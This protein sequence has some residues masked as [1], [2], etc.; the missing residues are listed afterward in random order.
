MRLTFTTTNCNGLYTVCVQDPVLPMAEL[1]QRLSQD[2]GWDRQPP[3]SA[4]TARWAVSSLYDWQTTDTDLQQFCRSF[5][6]PDIKRQLL[7]LAAQDPIFQDHWSRPDIDCFSEI[8]SSYAYYV[9]TPAR[10]EDHPWHTD[11]KNLVIQGMLYI[12]LDESASQGTWFTRDS[13]VLQNENWVDLT[14]VSARPWQGWLLINSD[15]SY[16][17]GLNYSDVP[18]Y[19]LKFGIQLNTQRPP[20]RH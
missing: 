7:E 20:E 4:D 15:R 12:V 11:S 13:A 2:P 3:G 16:H 8:S 10:Y 6:D 5:N 9:E 17:R 1:H 19:C 14:K 18:R